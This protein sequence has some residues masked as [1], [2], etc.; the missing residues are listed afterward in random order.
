MTLF[1]SSY[2]VIVSNYGLCITPPWTT[3]SMNFT[4]N[5]TVVSKELNSTASQQSFELL[6]HG[7]YFKILWLSITQCHL[8]LLSNIA[9]VVTQSR[10]KQG[11]TTPRRNLAR[12][13]TTAQI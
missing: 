2:K 9:K 8:T 7:K 3:E 5:R 10:G 13:N 4:S 11:P 6:W 12:I 1:D